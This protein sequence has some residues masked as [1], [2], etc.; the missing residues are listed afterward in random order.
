MS[1]ARGMYKVERVPEQIDRV[2][3]KCHGRGCVGFELHRVTVCVGLR[4]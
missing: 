1:V 2:P 4:A 3:I